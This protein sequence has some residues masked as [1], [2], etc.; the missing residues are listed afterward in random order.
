M[1]DCRLAV[2]IS[3]LQKAMTIPRSPPPTARRADSIINCRRSRPGPAPEGG[4]N[5]KL[6]LTA[7]GG[8]EKEI[9]NIHAGDEQDETNRCAKNEEHWSRPA[10]EEILGQRIDPGGVAAVGLGIGLGEAFGDGLQLTIRIGSAHPGAQPGDR[11]R[12]GDW[13]RSSATSP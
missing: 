9:G 11:E 2:R 13:P 1:V 4:A 3:T 12:S 7:Y 10:A 5:G 6:P 8:G